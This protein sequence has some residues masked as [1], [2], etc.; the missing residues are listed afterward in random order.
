[1]KHLIIA[2]LL[3]TFN[4]HAQ[5][6]QKRPSWSQG[7]PERQTTIK[8]E[9][10]RFNTEPKTTTD[11]IAPDT[12][13]RPA[14]PSI[15]INLSTAPVI[16]LNV[17]PQTP[18]V[19]A[20]IAT[21]RANA[22]TSYYQQP[23]TVS[24]EPNPLLAEYSWNILKTTPISIPGRIKSNDN[25]KLRIQ[26]NP[27]GKVIRVTAADPSVSAIIMRHAENSIRNWQF[28]PPEEIGISENISKVFTIE[29]TPS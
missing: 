12:S 17:Q 21:N 25:L 1:M 7:L 22:L 24:N 4:S 3:L 28:Q 26:I 20:P 27:Q 5:D 6:D 2:S 11:V 10:Q 8:P 9:K 19:D 23:Q 29:I 14:A 16:E 13:E 18:P 15:E